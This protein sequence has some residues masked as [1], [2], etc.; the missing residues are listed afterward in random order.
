M[1]QFLFMILHKKVNFPTLHHFIKCK[2]LVLFHPNA[3]E[4]LCILSLN[5]L[6]HNCKV[7][8]M[9]HLGLHVEGDGPHTV[10]NYVK[11]LKN[12]AKS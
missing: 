9:V 11:K 6:N 3:F 12:V 5:D 7:I 4:R 8:I 1:N 10:C 2:L